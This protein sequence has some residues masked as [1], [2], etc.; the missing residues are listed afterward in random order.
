MGKEM[1]A[2]KK[3]TILCF[4]MTSSEILCNTIRQTFLETAKR[5]SPLGQYKPSLIYL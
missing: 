2:R 3:K 4:T 1:Y 5:L